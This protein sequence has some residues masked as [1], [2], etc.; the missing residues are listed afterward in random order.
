MSKR[1]AMIF[2]MFSGS[3]SSATVL[4]SG[5]PASIHH[6]KSAR[7]SAVGLGLAGWRHGERQ[8]ETGAGTGV[9][10]ARNPGGQFQHGQQRNHADGQMHEQRMQPAHEQKN[11]RW[12][13]QGEQKLREEP[14]FTS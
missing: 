5:A 2:K 8:N 3:F 4:I 7:S 10:E 6:L 14:D 13:I 11:F 1:A 9:F 12:M